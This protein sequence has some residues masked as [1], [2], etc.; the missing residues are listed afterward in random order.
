[1]RFLLRRLGFLVLTL[2]T[3]VLWGRGMDPSWNLFIL[4]PTQPIGK[5]YEFA[6]DSQWNATKDIFNALPITTRPA[7]SVF[8]MGHVERSPTD[9]GVA[10]TG[11]S[12]GAKAGEKR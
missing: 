7:G 1:M 11:P 5:V 12:A 2:R 9:P 10:R 8:T 6:K 4:G 3:L